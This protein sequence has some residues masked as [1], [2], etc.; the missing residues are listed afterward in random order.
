MFTSLQSHRTAIKESNDYTLSPLPLYTWAVR[1]ALFALDAERAHDWTMAALGRAVVVRALARLP[2]PPRDSRLAQHV[3]GLAFDHP[4]GLA[5]GLDKHG[6]AAGAWAAV[7]FAFAEMGTVTPLPQPGNPRPRLFRLPTHRG[8]INR[9][10]FNSVGAAAVAANLAGVVPAPI[11]IG[12]NLGKNKSTPNDRAAEDY[13]RVLE[14]LHP[15]ADYIVI[16]VSSPNTAGLRD[17]QDSR[18]LRR[19]VEAVVRRASE[20]TTRKTI[21]VLVKLSPDAEVGDLLASVDAALEGG[22]SG[23]VATNTTVTRQGLDALP[24]AAETGGLSGLPLRTLANDVCRILFAHV[25][26][27]VPII[28]VGGIFT[29]DDAYQRIRSGASLVQLYTALVYE[30]PGVVARIVRGLRR[31]IA[32]DGLS[33]ISEA[34]GADAR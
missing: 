12:V 8:I 29:A 33:H 34:I 31:R 1:P 23:L 5:A 24:T 28:G 7:G 21:P 19:L 30:G 11:R 9:F 22:A 20:L 17:L 2:R 32:V 10:G 26:R 13:E 6:A 15:Y 16:N 25:G 3:L 4:V 14:V 27:R 18:A